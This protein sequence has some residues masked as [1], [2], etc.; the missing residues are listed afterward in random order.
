MTN[1]NVS[2]VATQALVSGAPSAQVKVA[3]AQVLAS[4]SP[5]ARVKVV[6][7]QVLAQAINSGDVAAA[8]PALTASIAGTVSPPV[9]TTTGSVAAALPA[10]TAAV[11]GTVTIRGQVAA[12]LP[13]LTAAISG[14][15]SDVVGGAIDATLPAITA[16][17]SGTATGSI[18]GTVQAV[19]PPL[20]ARLNAAD[21]ADLLSAHSTTSIT[22]H[23]AAP[24]VADPIA[25]H[26]VTHI[27]SAIAAP[28]TFE[29]ISAHST[30][31]ITSSVVPG[32]VIAIDP[33]T[34]RPQYR[35]FVVDRQG[36]PL[37]ELENARIGDPVRT[38]Q[39]AG[40]FTATLPKN[41]PKATLL[42]VGAE[43]QVWAGA[44]M[45]PD[46]WFVLV[47]PGKDGG[48]EISYQF[49]GLEGLLDN[50]VIGKER[51]DLLVNGGFEDGMS[52]WHPVALAGSASMAPPK[53]TIVTGSAAKE[54]GKAL[55]VE[56]VE[57]VNVREVKTAAIF[58]GNRPYASEPLSAGFL[59][60]GEKVITD[61]LPAFS[62]GTAL[63]VEG[64]TADVD[65]GTGMALS[66]RRA[67]AAKAVILKARPDLKVTAIGRGE[68]IQVAPNN[69]PEN[70]A[71]NR[72]ILL[73][74]TATRVGHRQVVQQF[75]KYRNST[76][77]P[78]DLELDGWINLIQYVGPSKDRYGF[79]I[80]RRNRANLDTDPI[81]P[82]DSDRTLLEE[83]AVQY[84]GMTQAKAEGYDTAEALY[85]AI[86]A[87]TPS[88]AKIVAA[89]HTDLSEDF[90]HEKWE[91]DGTSIIAPPDGRE[92]LYEVRLYGSAG[93][94]KFD[95]VS[96][97]PNVVTGFYNVT[98]PQL[99]AGLVA[100]AQDP[101]FFKVDLNIDAD[102]PAVGIRGDY[103]YEHKTPR[104][105]WDAISEQL[106]SDDS[107]DFWIQST[108]QRRV[109][110]TAVK[111][112][113]RS[114]VRFRLGDIVT[115][116]TAGVDGGKVATTG[117]VTSNRSRGGGV[118][119]ARVR[120]GPVNGLV[121]ERVQ[122][123]EPDRSTSRLRQ[124]GAA[125]VR[126]GRTDVLTSVTCDPEWTVYLLGHVGLGDV[127]WFEVKDGDT[128]VAGWYRI[129]E[130][131]HSISKHQLSYE[132]APEV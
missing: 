114:P 41:D 120:T 71:K 129:V 59:P 93:K 132:L 27:T 68:T 33:V 103:E 127:A 50:V 57:S 6:A 104:T 116:Y 1:A 52:H 22:S 94:T 99:F 70:Q 2:A 111:R 106:R 5:A 35:L 66:Q 69:T 107:P 36:N 109:A 76:R 7:V 20:V 64:F 100:H 92:Y 72:R 121:L 34:N 63:L 37:G 56:A 108:P 124:M 112:G 62:Q 49:V 78:I 123:A 130:I 81:P 21:P 80:N 82:A 19:L 31:R 115:G 25:A 89:E 122:S 54:G 3:A 53:T 26:S 15:V 101:E 11:T 44:E 73:T 30:T 45:L 28:S 18:T 84:A 14:Q 90:P 32:L 65:S 87:A 16:A 102:C 55:Q 47:E 119:E 51:P 110:R 75:F 88:K 38:L 113:R 79:Y 67:D 86:V 9:V 40:V 85:A 125:M 8:L 117:I 126:Y 91:P 43:V 12:T 42:D 58:Y 131:R 4:G 39:G 128:D 17:I 97:K 105:V 83:Y 29:F 24:F 74:G 60:G 98:R 46:A 23:V 13:T 96:C 77:A 95:E 10:V 48:G 61:Q 118:A